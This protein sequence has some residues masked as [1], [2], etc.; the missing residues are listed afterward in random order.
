VL[1]CRHNGGVATS[2]NEKPSFAKATDGSLR[3][4][5]DI[6]QF[7]ALRTFARRLACQP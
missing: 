1:I 3:L 7:Q 4:I 2:V 5:L 6:R